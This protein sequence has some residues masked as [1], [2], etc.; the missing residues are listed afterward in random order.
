M[1]GAPVVIEGIQ[2]YAPEL[3]L[4]NAAYPRESY[5]DLYRSEAGSFWF[6]SRQRIIENLVQ[7]YLHDR[8]AEFFEVGCGTGFVLKGLSR[9]ENLRLTGA[10]LNLSGLKWAKQRLTGIDLLQLDVTRLPFKNRFDAIGAFD[11][12]EHIDD[13]VLALQNMYAALKAGGFLLLTVPQHQFL[14]SQADEFGLH[15]RRYSRKELL[16]KLKQ[17][18]FAI[19]FIS[20]FIFILFPALYIARLFKHSKQKPATLAVCELNLPRYIDFL[21]E[22]LMRLEEKLINAGFSFPWG[23]SLVVVAQKKYDIHS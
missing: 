15:K 2:C 11:V 16:Q 13:D 22:W 6:R 9:F 8:L 20:S 7:K 18:G 17:A 19:R 1:S 5:E 21:G 14:W 12:I 3:A 4:D 23:G 10:E